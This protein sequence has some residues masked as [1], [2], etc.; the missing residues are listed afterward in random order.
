MYHLKN[1]IFD[2]FSGIQHVLKRHHHDLYNNDST[3][4]S[5]T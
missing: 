2:C 4:K 3:L 5:N 1:T